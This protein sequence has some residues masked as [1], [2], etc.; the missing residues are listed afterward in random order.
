MGLT[1]L[2]K[3]GTVPV[4]GA[5]GVGGGEPTW[6]IRHVEM[7]CWGWGSCSDCDTRAER[8]SFKIMAKFGFQVPSHSSCSGP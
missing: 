5:L 8:S 2:R 1:T 4:F 6:A 7:V 3:G